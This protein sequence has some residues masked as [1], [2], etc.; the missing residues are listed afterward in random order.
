MN[1]K[2]YPSELK[3]LVEVPPSKSITH[4]AL[5]CAAFSKGRSIIHNP[6]I[7]ED[8]IA[9][10]KCLQRI[11]VDIYFY[12]KYLIIDGKNIFVNPK[13]LYDTKESASTLRML[14][15]LFSIF[16]KNL[17]FSGTERL[18]E[19]IFTDDL[20][21]LT[22]LNIIKEDNILKV[23]GNL[24]SKEFILSGQ[25]TSQLIS[26]MILALPFL[27]NSELILKDIDFKN[28][29]LE[30]TLDTASKFGLEFNYDY[31]R[32]SIKLKEGST[33]QPTE[34][35]IEGDFSNGAYW[36]AASILNPSL[37]VGNLNPNSIQGDKDFINF[38]QM[39]NVNFTYKNHEYKYLSGN[40]G[41]SLIDINKTPDLGPILVSIASL[42]KGKVI[43][44][45]TKKLFYKESNRAL[46]IADGIN[47]LGGNVLVEEDRIIIE[48]KDFLEGDVILDSYNDH[49]IVMALT[50]ISSF[51][52]KPYI[53]KDFLAVKKSYP[54]F[55]EDFQKLG[56][57]VEVL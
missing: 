48:G 2:I 9:T 24:N 7:S 23:S 55:F 43:L 36:L 31:Q 40:I 44:S 54:N 45:N 46:A 51:S 34:I 17:N 18:I 16:V 25:I 42:G 21:S 12:E 8:T 3:G 22:G 10:I 27:S 41:N 52:K 26:G 33:Y 14:L 20:H 19:R 11:G 28:P 13:N 6:L 1:I 50:V 39:M 56:G 53:I 38:L 29:Y 49:R 30:L 37:R 57:K 47:K 4:R 5:I 32:N 35:F 15:P